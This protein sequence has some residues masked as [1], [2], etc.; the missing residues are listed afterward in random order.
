ME[1]HILSPKGETSFLIKSIEINTSVGNM[2]IMPLHAP[3]IGNIV[4]G[5]TVTIIQE[6]KIELI[7][8]PIG[9]IRVASNR[10]T[11]L[12]HEE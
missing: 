2:V 4:P 11:L 9:V 8:V 6:E 10:V 1:L 7:S 5:S 12:M 3:F